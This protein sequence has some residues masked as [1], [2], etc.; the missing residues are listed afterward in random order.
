MVIWE[1]GLAWQVHPATGWSLGAKLNGTA[2]TG[3]GLRLLDITTE[4]GNLTILSSGSG[5]GTGIGPAWAA[6]HRILIQ[7]WAEHVCSHR[8]DHAN[9]FLSHPASTTDS[10]LTRT[11]RHSK[12]RF[13]VS[14]LAV[15][16]RQR[17]A[18]WTPTVN[19]CTTAACRTLLLVWC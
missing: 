18:C 1:P 7:L 16:L 11:W 12:T 14:H 15:G 13:R 4:N 10:S 6:S 2:L 3:A 9:M 19:D 5:T 17:C 8:Q